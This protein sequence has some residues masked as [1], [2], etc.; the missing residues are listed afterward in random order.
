MKIPK[1]ILKDSD[2]MFTQI[3]YDSTQMFTPGEPGGMKAMIDAHNYLF[4][5]GENTG[6]TDCRIPIAGLTWHT[7]RQPVCLNYWK[8]GEHAS[9]LSAPFTT[10]MNWTAGK[11]LQYNGEAWGQKDIEFKKVL[12]LPHLVSDINFSAIVNQTG[13]TTKAFNKEDIENSGWKILDAATHAATW[14]SYQ[15]FIDGSLAEFSVAKETYVKANTGW[16]SCR[17]ACYLAA[18]KPVV[19]QDTCWSKY[20]PAGNGLFAFTDLETAKNAVEEVAGNYKIHALHAR[21][22]AEEYFDSNKVLGRLLSKVC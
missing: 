14:Q 16:F 8:P 3:Q 10:L 4:T 15:Q 22:I 1:R 2:P 7:T 20:I 18:G 11:Q 5:F 21:E 19:T 12:S 9:S 6:A 13:G 17:S